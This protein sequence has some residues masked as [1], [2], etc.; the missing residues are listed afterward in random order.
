MHDGMVGSNE[1]DY[2]EATALHAHWE[3]FFD[4][5]SGVK[6]YEYIYHTKCWA[7]DDWKTAIKDNVSVNPC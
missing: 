7:Q 4:K 1:I 2:Q 6:F 3:G 5:E